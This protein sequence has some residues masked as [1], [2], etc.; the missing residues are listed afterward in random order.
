MIFWSNGIANASMW[1]T[2]EEALKAHEINHASEV[3]AETE[4][5]S[6]FGYSQKD[7]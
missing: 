3:E 7:V 5:Y 1:M 6:L 4:Y 2:L